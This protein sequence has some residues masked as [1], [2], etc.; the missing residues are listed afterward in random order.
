M[1][2]R[3]AVCD[4]WAAEA[5]LTALDAGEK[6]MLAMLDEGKKLHNWLHEWVNKNY[7]AECMRAAG[8]NG[9]GYTYKDA[10][11][12]IHSMNY[13]A[14]PDKI[15]ASAG[16][17]FYV[18]QAI[19]SFYHGTFPGI[20]LRMSKIEND[21][22]TRGYLVSPL[23]RKRIF[24]SPW[25]NKLLQEAYAWKS[26][27]AIGE[28]TN[29][30]LTKLY[31][32]GQLHDPWLFPALNTH[33]GLVIRFYAGQEEAV[34]KKIISAFNIPITQYGIT[35]RIPVEIAFGDNFNDMKDEKVYWYQ[36]AS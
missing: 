14:R 17:P 11:Q 29:I 10:K 8:S 34:A 15:A 31:W 5:Y 18:G 7:P 4:L 23:G 26:Q 9:I 12:S 1:E 30:G 25:N 35:V 3:L 6:S 13:G 20:Q 24:F 27:S 19:Y 22:R 16:L 28:L 36:E 32:M 21:L 33:D 2:E